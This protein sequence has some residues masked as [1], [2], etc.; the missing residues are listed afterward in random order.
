M[1][2]GGTKV[3]CCVP[4]GSG[5]CSTRGR[6]ARIASMCVVDAV[7]RPR[8]VMT[9][10]TSIASRSVRPIAQFAQRALQHRRACGRRPPPAGTARAAPSSAGR[11]CRRPRRCTSA[12]TCSASAEESTIIA[13]CPPVSAIS[14]IGWPLRRQPVGQLAL[15]QPRDLGRA[16]EH[17]GRGLRR[18]DQRRAD[19]AVAG[20]ELQRVCGNAGLVQDAHGLGGDQRRFLGRLGQHRVAGDQRRRDLAG[21]D[22]QREVPRADADDRAQRPMRVGPKSSGAPGRRNSAGNRPPRAPRRWRWAADLPASRMIRPSSFG[23]RASIRS[24]ARIE[25]GGA[26][27]PAASRPRPRRM[28]RQRRSAA[29]IW[30]A[31]R[32]SRC[33]P[34]SRWSAGLRTVRASPACAVGQQ[35]HAP[36]SRVVGAGEQRCR[37]RGQRCFVRQVEP[38]GVARAVPIEVA[39]QGDLS[40]AARRPARWRRATVDRVGDQLVDRDVGIGDAVDEGGVGAVL[41]QP[42]HE[43]GE[44]RLV[45]AD[46]RIDAARPVRAC[47]CRRPRRRAARPCRAGTGIRNRRR[48]IAG[49]ASCVDRRQRLRIVG[50]E[51]RE[52]RIAAPPAACGR[53]RCR[54][55]RC[56]PCGCRPGSRPGPSTCARLISAVPIGALDQPHHDAGGPRGGPRSMIQSIT[57][58]QRLP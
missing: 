5:S 24:A 58:G 50:R 51:L 49:P 19:R 38:G 21:E 54:R 31:K 28:S 33:R 37:Q 12:T 39:R 40:G 47:P 41:Q 34:T 8:R 1:I 14:G 2:V 32:R 11:R 23:I 36:A 18:A 6:R 22:R 29:S 46:R 48:E 7:L 9:G 20:Q 16:G 57:K 17:H 55:R 44:Q 13:F 15:D 26:L 25:A 42:A 30:S 52:D 4:A 56:G 3:P 10:P 35:R 27:G 45:R 43:I 53:R